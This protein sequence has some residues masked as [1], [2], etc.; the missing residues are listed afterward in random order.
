M[1]MRFVF[2]AAWLTAGLPAALAAN[3]SVLKGE[4]LVSRGEGYET[5]KGSANFAP[6]DTIVPKSGSSVKVTFSNGCTLF[7]GGGM[8]FSVPAEPPCGGPSPVSGGSGALQQA[9]PAL[10]QNWTAATQ[11]T[12]FST[13]P[14]NFTPYLIGAAAVGGISAAAVAL[15]GGRSGN[16]T[17]P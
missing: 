5:L 7:L 12:A 15:S 14:M 1:R 17:S 11:T 2:T 8:M 3:V 9:D 16:P 10:I 13:T 6:G 4:A